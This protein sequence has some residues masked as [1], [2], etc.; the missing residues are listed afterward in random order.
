MAPHAEPSLLVFP[1]RAIV[2]LHISLTS[3]RILFGFNIT[4]FD[5]SLSIEPALVNKYCTE[6]L[7]FTHKNSRFVKSLILL[8]Y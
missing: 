3:E 8:F 7:S 5:H 4:H 2:K 1:A 6:M